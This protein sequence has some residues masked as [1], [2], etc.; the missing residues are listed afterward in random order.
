MRWIFFFLITTG[1]SLLANDSREN[2][3]SQKVPEKP[4]SK[5]S[6]VLKAPKNSDWDYKSSIELKVRQEINFPRDT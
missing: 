6:K 1:A 3:P 5:E 2:K 4:E